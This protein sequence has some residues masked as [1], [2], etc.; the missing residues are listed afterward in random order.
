MTE[1]GSTKRAGLE[2][3]F[4]GQAIPDLAAALRESPQL[5]ADRSLFFDLVQADYR[6]L[7]EG[8]PAWAPT[9]YCDRLGLRDSALLAS[10]RRMVEVE[11]YFVENPSFLAEVGEPAWPCPGEAF[12]GF[13]LIDELGRGAASRVFLARDPRRGNR[14]V[15]LKVTTLSTNEADLLGRADLSGVVPIHWHGS[16]EESG[17]HWL[18]MPFHGRRTLQ[19]E[20]DKARSSGSGGLGIKRAVRIGARIAG[21]LAALADI[22]VFHG[23]LKP[24]N[25]LLLEDDQPMLIDFNLSRMDTA[26]SA[27]VGG[28]LPYMAPEVLRRIVGASDTPLSM[29]HGTAIASDVFSFGSLLFQVQTGRLWAEHPA[30]APS[31]AGLAL[32]MLDAQLEAQDGLPSRLAGTPDGF[33]ALV[34]SCLALSPAGRPS[35]FTEIESELNKLDQDQQRRRPWIR[36]LGG[37]GGGAI[38]VGAMILVVGTGLPRSDVESILEAQRRINR[39]HV[40]QAR[41]LLAGVG[42]SEA[43]PI[44]SRRSLGQT[45]LA[46]GRLSE[47]AE[48]LEAIGREHRDPSAYAQAG[49]A[50]HLLGSHAMAI[51]RDRKALA[52]GA[53]P[54]SAAVSNNLAAGLTVGLSGR[55]DSDASSEIERLLLD[56]ARQEPLSPTICFNILRHTEILSEQGILHGYP[57][58]ELL[59]RCETSDHVGFLVL[60]AKHL[61]PTDSVGTAGSSTGLDLLRR[62]AGQLPVEVI[63]D[64]I[65]NERYDAYA[66]LPGFALPDRQDHA[67][68]AYSDETAGTFYVDPSESV[69]R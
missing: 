8:G 10:V 2:S 5:T 20:I 26:P 54:A 14:K 69:R 18:C 67:R 19:D 33:A 64:L 4:G 68:S 48:V 27:L 62:L 37:L 12:A 51:D 66:A 25:V 58:A 9:A 56:A 57:L 47:A 24:S 35:T 21:T 17:L 28:T 63:T 7:A 16:V 61:A 36:R 50:L 3:T 49:Y 39:G 60:G 44:D 40:N 43:L 65:G 52:L 23:D 29:G 1:P 13:D 32:S 30:E 31:A 22:G 42:D 59:A 46:V 45:L 6:R 53:G 11:K 34:R 41:D 38:A 55:F 15:A